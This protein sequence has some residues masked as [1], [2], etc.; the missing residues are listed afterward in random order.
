MGNSRI[1]D[2]IDG[3][4]AW[5]EV[6]LLDIGDYSAQTLRNALE[7]SGIQVNLRTI[8][9]SRHVVAALGGSRSVAPYVIVSCHGDDCR[10]LL[11]EFGGSI[12]EAQPFNG[13]MGP[14]QIRNQTPS[15]EKDRR[16]RL[17]LPT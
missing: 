7:E 16:R 12:A 6:D 5:V 15:T 11:P 8:G 10:I 13:W 9:Q 14:E 4:L 3:K 2:I 17:W 1:G